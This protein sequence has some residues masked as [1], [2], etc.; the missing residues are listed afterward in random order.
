MISSANCVEFMFKK[1][2]CTMMISSANCAEFIFRKAI[3]T[4]SGGGI[5]LEAKLSCAFARWISPEGPEI[6]TSVFL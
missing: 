1:A 6:F 5:D 4:I 3:C 2:I